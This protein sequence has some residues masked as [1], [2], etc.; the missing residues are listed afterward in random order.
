[1]ATLISHFYNE[2]YLLPYWLDHHKRIFDNGIMI[3]YDST[4]NSVDIIKKCCPNWKIIK[5][6]NRDFGARA[7]DSEVMQIEQSINDWK[8]VLNTTEFLVTSNLNGILNKYPKNT[9]LETNGI[10][11]CGESEVP[12]ILTIKKGVISD[13]NRR[14][15]KIHNYEK[16]N[17]IDGRHESTHFCIRENMYTVWY[18]HFPWNESTIQRKLQIQNRIPEYDKIMRLGYQHITTR[19][20]LNND[21]LKF[22]ENVYDLFEDYNFKQIFLNMILN[23]YPELA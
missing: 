9:M 5:S 10:A 4:D 20:A 14:N 6:I 17:Y 19:D 2:E 15:R 12:S 13:N 1:M 3:D 23:Y 22:S 21:Y 7:V 18:S 11:V 8:M 16:G